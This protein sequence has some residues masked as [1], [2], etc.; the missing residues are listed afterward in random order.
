MRQG[1]GITLMPD[2]LRKRWTT[3][4]NCSITLL[5]IACLYGLF[6]CAFVA[7]APGSVQ[8]VPSTSSTPTVTA[9]GQPGSDICA[10]VSYAVNSVL[11]STG[12]TVLLSAQNYS[13]CLSGT[14]TIS[15]NS[16]TIRGAGTG[17]VLSGTGATVINMP[18]A[19][20]GF[21][22][23]GSHD[24]LEDF[25]LNSASS[26]LGTD[27]GVQLYGGAPLLRNLAVYHFGQYGI[28]FWGNSPYSTDRWRLDSIEVG[29]CFSDAYYWATPASDNN[30][31][32]CTLCSASVNGG[33]GFNLLGGSGN[34]FI[35]SS[36]QGNSAGG[37][38]VA[39][40]S[41]TFFIAYAEQGTGSSFVID[42]TTLPVGT[43]AWFSPFG[44][45]STIS[46]PPAVASQTQIFQ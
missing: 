36:V 38:H 3:L 13:T 42:S 31:G 20:T 44:L 1:K 2:R 41:N 17:W 11:P 45:P 18:A 7:G 34:T 4:T 40:S 26:A 46:V 32:V 21:K 9:D 24:S 35:N 10:K 39:A 43:R 28:S 16:V 12:G 27:D 29:G 37:W 22:L 6:G 19:T 8:T 15:K 25:T 5:V 33:W 23:M 30:I 14:V